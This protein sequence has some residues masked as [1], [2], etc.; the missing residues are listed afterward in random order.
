MFNAAVVR[1]VTRKEIAATPAAARA[2]KVEWD[3]LRKKKVWD[4]RVIREWADV[5][6]D[7]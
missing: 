1:P 4:E 5:T 6:R 2:M 7:A 3:R